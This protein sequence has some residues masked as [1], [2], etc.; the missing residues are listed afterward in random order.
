MNF[1]VKVVLHECVVANI[2]INKV[3]TFCSMIETMNFCE[4]TPKVRGQYKWPKLSELSFKLFKSEMKNAHNSYYD[5]VN[6]AKCYFG[7]IELGW[8]ID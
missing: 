2:G 8:I 1:D 6:C 4:I 3:D 5:V 7:L